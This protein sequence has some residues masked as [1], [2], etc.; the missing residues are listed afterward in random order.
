[1]RFT[2]AAKICKKKIFEGS[3]VYFRFSLAIVQYKDSN[4]EYLLMIIIRVFY[5]LEG[6]GQKTA[7]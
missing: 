3:Y 6:V 4:V 2:E 7:V 1:M 5:S